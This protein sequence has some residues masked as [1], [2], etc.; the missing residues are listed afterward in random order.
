MATLTITQGSKEGAYKGDD[1]TYAATLV[2]CR[3]VGKGGYRDEGAPPFPSKEDGKDDY[4]LREW[5]FA[6]DDAPGDANMVWRRTSLITSAK[7][8]AFGFIVAL[9][10]GKAPPVGHTFDIE[11]DL[12]GRMA[13]V[14]IHRNPEGYVDVYSVTALPKAMQKPAA[15]KAP[16]PADTDDAPF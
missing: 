8:N 14:A 5:A 7:S 9:F 15:P 6:I 2:S 13:L 10:G 16:E 4:Y 12:V 1:G 3:E 11:K